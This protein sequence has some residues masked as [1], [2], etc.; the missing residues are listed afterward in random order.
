[1]PVDRRLLAANAESVLTFDICQD[2]LKSAIGIFMVLLFSHSNGSLFNVFLATV[3]ENDVENEM[4]GELPF[5]RLK[6]GDRK[7]GNP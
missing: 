4:S 5:S 6:M 3:K 1:M 7:Q 2:M